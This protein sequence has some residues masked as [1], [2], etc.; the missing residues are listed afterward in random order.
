MRFSSGDHDPFN[1]ITG[2]L[3][4]LV[5]RITPDCREVTRLTSEGRDRP[6]PLGTRL[7]IGLHRRFCK[8]CARYAR[9]LDFLHK[10][11]HLFAAHVDQLSGP[12][13]NTDAKSRMKRTLQTVASGESRQRRFATEYNDQRPV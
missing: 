13:L 12:S 2:K 5:W 7:R 9:Q 1:W 4:N 11:N 6:L 8:W 3:V 10:A